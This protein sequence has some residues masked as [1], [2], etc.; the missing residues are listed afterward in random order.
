ML[1][2]SVAQRD[3]V[4]VDAVDEEL[5]VRRPRTGAGS[6]EASVLLPEPIG[7][8]D[9]ERRCRPGTRSDDVAQRRLAA[10][11]GV[12]EREAR[13]TRS[14]RAARASG[15]RVGAVRDRRAARRAPRRCAASTPRRAAR[16]PPPSPCMKVGKVSS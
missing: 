12:A 9:A 11:A 10:D 15:T 4:D 1:A 6:R 5:A 8:D 16:A 14:R 3:P 7:P 13:G 2:R